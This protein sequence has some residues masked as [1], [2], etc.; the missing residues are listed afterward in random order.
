MISNENIKFVNQQYKAWS[1]WKDLQAGL[2]V[3][4]PKKIIPL[5]I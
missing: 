3:Y 1:E 5:G 2:A 4:Y